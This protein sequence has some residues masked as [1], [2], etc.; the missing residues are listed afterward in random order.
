MRADCLIVGVSAGVV[1]RSC[2][3]RRR[4]VSAET[5]QKKEDGAVVPSWFT[6]SIAT[7]GIGR[8]KEPKLAV[9]ES[10]GFE[11]P[12]PCGLTDFKSAAFDRSANSPDSKAILRATSP[13]QFA[14]HIK[15]EIAKFT[16]IGNAAGIKAE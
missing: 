13:E 2:R 14:A 9:A 4:C 6:T 16:R 11:P 12:S 8:G 10:E 3:R 7:A 1:T 5:N 15:S